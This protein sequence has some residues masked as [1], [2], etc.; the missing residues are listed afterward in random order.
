[1]AKTPKTPT[2]PAKGK[3]APKR[4]SVDWDAV[5]RDFRTG[6]FTLREL[7][8]KHGVSHAAI[9]KRSRDR[10]WPQDLS[11][12]IRQ[13]TNAKLTAE[14]VSMETEKSFQAVSTTVQAAAEL[15]KQ[16]ILGHRTDI[17][18]TRN[19]AADLLQELASAALLAENQELL[20]K[21]VAGEGATPQQEAQARSIVVKALSVNTRISSI[22][23]L[24]ETFSKLQESERKA[25]SIDAAKPEA[26]TDSLAE[27]LADLSARGSRLPTNGGAA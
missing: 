13:A 23:A 21:I 9:G 8:G 4:R 15:N 7:G 18:A 5:E 17:L 10:Q 19:V 6:K 26:P 16:V 24:A 12:Q 3:P 11:E 20:E 1:V 2:T 14:L 27:F 22:K 25:F